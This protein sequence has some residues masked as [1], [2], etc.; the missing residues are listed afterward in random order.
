MGF[1]EEE[2]SFLSGKGTGNGG[3][4]NES[5]GNGKEGSGSSGLNSRE[6][7]FWLCNIENV[8]PVIIEALLKYFK[9][10]E[11]VYDA[12]EAELLKINGIGKTRINNIMKGKEP[13]IIRRK[14]EDMEK[15]GIHFLSYYDEAFPQK[16][17]DIENPPYWI[18]YKGRL[19]DVRFPVL[20]VVGARE[21][22]GYG[23]DV[24]KYLSCRLSK[25][26]VQII[27]GM[28]RGIDSAAHRGALLA[29]GYGREPERGYGSETEGGCSSENPGRYFSENGAPTFAVLGCGVDVC[30]PPENY[31]LYSEINKNGGIIS[32]YPMGIGPFPGNFPR[33][34][35]II[36]GL[37][38]GIL[39]IEARE[40]SGSLITANLG[41]GQ[42]KD[43]FAVPGRINDELSKGCNDLIRLGAGLTEKPEDI[44]DS[45]AMR[46]PY[47]FT[48]FNDKSAQNIKTE[49]ASGLSAFE[50]ILYNCLT[51]EPKHISCILE[52]SGLGFSQLIEGLF[53]LE[54]KGMIQMCGQNYYRRVL[55]ESLPL[56]IS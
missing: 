22:S 51:V 24:A 27:S 40:R 31:S 23:R 53:D 17:R 29:A 30:Y 11:A 7:W 21:C 5:P 16:L 38:D 20:A 9:E 56:S 55:G 45:L 28:A 1:K 36:S 26:G 6:L 3:G 50:E 33:R 46:F 54:K 47:L 34:N 19:P 15:K 35:R 32:E 37:S 10:P 8:G 42:G 13:E 49:T 2:D 4:Q 48:E 39:V 44:L 43:V 52:E 14:M 41:L 25:C 18:Y 12:A